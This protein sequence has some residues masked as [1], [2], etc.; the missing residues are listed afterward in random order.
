MLNKLIMFEGINDDFKDILK[1]N[2]RSL[3]ASQ[4]ETDIFTEDEQNPYNVMKCAVLPILHVKRFTEQFPKSAEY[5]KKKII[6][7]DKYAI[8]PYNFMRENIDPEELDEFIKVSRTY[9]IYKNKADDDTFKNVMNCIW[10]KLNANN[11][12]ID[13][14]NIFI[15]N[16]FRNQASELYLYRQKEPIDITGHMMDLIED[17]LSL[18][19]IIFFCAKKTVEEDV[20][21]ESEYHERIDGDDRWYRSLSKYIL[22]SPAAEAKE[23]EGDN[24]VSRFCNDCKKT[25]LESFEMLP[26]RYERIDITNMTH[27]S[28]WEII[29]QKIELIYAGELNK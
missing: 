12:K 24:G 21:A 23:L 26:V 20:K 3:L 19:P 22:S 15:G 11:S 14:V 8:V 2:L 13:R 5:I 18:S 28:L 4:M 29:K 25:L 7:V 1:N 9:S 6:V 16:F 17:V 27:E 10:K